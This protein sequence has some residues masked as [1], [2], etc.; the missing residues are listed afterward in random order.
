MPD[1]EAAGPRGKDV[2]AAAAAGEGGGGG[3]GARPPFPLL[4][5]KEDADRLSGLWM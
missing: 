5:E 1:E 3:A 2:V 4:F